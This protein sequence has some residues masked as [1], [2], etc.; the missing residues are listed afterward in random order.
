MAKTNS[1]STEPHKFDQP[2]RRL[3]TYRE[4][5]ELEYASHL[6]PYLRILEQEI[7]RENVI[8]TLRKLALQEAEEYAHYVVEI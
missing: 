4:R 1:N 7:G 3:L 5:F 6:I 8:A 2:M